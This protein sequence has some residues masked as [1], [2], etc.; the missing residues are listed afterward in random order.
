MEN[1]VDFDIEDS[2]PKELVGESAV[3]VYYGY[4][5]KLDK[6]K[7]KNRISSTIT[8][9]ESPFTA[10]LSKTESDFLLPVKLGIV[11]RK[12]EENKIK[13][14]LLFYFKIFKFY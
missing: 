2:K 4:Y 5:K 7:D 3:N 8:T 12:G 1:S 11:K 10:I 14:T 13:I 9:I 6:I